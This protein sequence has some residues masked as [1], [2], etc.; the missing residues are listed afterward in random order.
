MINADMYRTLGIYI[1]KDS[2]ID[3]NRFDCSISVSKI[4]NH[5]INQMNDYPEGFIVKDKTLNDFLT[6]DARFVFGRSQNIQYAK[7]IHSYDELLE[8]LSVSGLNESAL[9]IAS[10]LNEFE[11]NTPPDITVKYNNS[12]VIHESSILF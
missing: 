12:I 8:V 11:F 4:K 2:I 10:W 5:I 9:F 6:G 7:I 3:T 1:D